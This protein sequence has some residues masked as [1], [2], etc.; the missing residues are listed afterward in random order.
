MQTKAM[1]AFRKTEETFTA[2]AKTLPQR[3][4]VS[5][6]IFAQEQQRIFSTR[7]L[8]VGHQSQLAKSGDY[9]VHEV[10]GESLTLLREQEGEARPFYNLCR[11]PATRSCEEK[12]GHLRQTIQCPYH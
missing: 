12:S 9:F 2:S 10:A 5:P 1:P 6:E 7:W 3:Y 11:H 4:L 8:C